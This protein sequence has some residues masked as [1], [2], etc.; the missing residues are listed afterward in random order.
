[1]Y[2]HTRDYPPLQPLLLAML[3]RVTGGYGRLAF[4]AL[5]LCLASLVAHGLTG[6]AGASRDAAWV[7]WLVVPACIATPM[8]VSPTS[9]A[10]DSGYAEL[11]L[12]TCVAA[13][14][15]AF[16]R[17]EPLLL[18]CSILLAIASKPE[19]L[20]YGLLPLLIAWC[21]SDRRMLAASVMGLA[22]GAL[23]WLP[24]QQHLQLSP[25]P[26]ALERL[27]IGVGGLAVGAAATDALLRRLRA[28]PRARW[29]TA[30]F[31][32]PL[33]LLVLP[34]L[35]ASVSHA[36]STMATYLDDAGRGSRRLEQLPAIAAGFLEYGVFRFSF[37][38]TFLLPLAAIL[39]LG[40]ASLTARTTPLMALLGLGLATVFAPFLLS[41]EPDLGHHLKSSMARLQL[42]WLGAAWLLG[43]ALLQ[44]MCRLRPLRDAAD[45]A[46]APDVLSP[47]P[48]AGIEAVTVHPSATSPP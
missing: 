42:H 36:G 47:L 45:A 27:G 5:L 43:G 14:A 46:P 44:E 38:A 2:C 26:A 1:V 41:P 25:H 15:A 19:G 29:T 10:A 31:A 17:A 39:A 12:C 33:L 11:L 28:T 22:A 3:D 48:R 23:T 35:L 34:A 20:V 32:A 7:R 21:R 37:G 16:L 24:V 30:L 13:M 9:G 4:P 18:G 8:L 40:K 6:P